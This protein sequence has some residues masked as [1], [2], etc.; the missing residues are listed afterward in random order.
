MPTLVSLLNDQTSYNHWK[1]PT[2]SPG[3]TKQRQGDLLL[4]TSGGEKAATWAPNAPHLSHTFP[5]LTVRPQEN[6]GLRH[7]SFEVSDM[8]CHNFTVVVLVCRRICIFIWG[9]CLWSRC[10]YHDTI[11]QWYLRTDSIWLKRFPIMWFYKAAG[12]LI[13]D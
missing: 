11:L 4:W 10:Y 6:S 5:R 9:P 1:F 13:P 3:L 2:T 8:F 12:I 7:E